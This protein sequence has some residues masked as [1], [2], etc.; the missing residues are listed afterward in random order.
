[1]SR[2]ECTPKVEYTPALDLRKTWVHPSLSFVEWR[3]NVIDVDREPG[4][5]GGTREWLVCP[6]C[7]KHFYILRAIGTRVA[8]RHCLGL[9]Y[10]CQSETADD[11][12][13]RR[14]N[15]LRERLG[16]EPGVINPPGWKPKYMRWATYERLRMEC[17]IVSH[18]VL[19]NYCAW[20][21]SHSGMRRCEYP[22]GN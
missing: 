14:A 9:K 20:V 6:E 15:K 10:K 3:G 5:L 8:C 2:R 22:S 11:R 16:W 19:M 12:L 13:L 21:R 18:R 7:R 1:M 17:L 4:R